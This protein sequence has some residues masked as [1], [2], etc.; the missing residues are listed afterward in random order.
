M[1][2]APAMILRLSQPWWGNSRTESLAV[3]HFRMDLVPPALLHEHLGRLVCLTECIPLARPHRL[4]DWRLAEQEPITALHDAA[5][6]E[7]TRIAPERG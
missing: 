1:G 6:N 2:L 4:D 5:P 7:V 3:C